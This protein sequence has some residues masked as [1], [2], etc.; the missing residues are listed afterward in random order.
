MRRYS[1]PGK[2]DYNMN[3]VL[4][5]IVRKAY[6]YLFLK[7]GTRRYMAPE[8]LEGAINFSRDAFLRID[9]YACGLVLWEIASRCSAQVGVS[10]YRIM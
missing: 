3:L 8:I 7:V 5:N 4:F 6:V 1:W 2:I 9:M 10:I